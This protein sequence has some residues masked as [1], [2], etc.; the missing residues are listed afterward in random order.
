M[1]LHIISEMLTGAGVALGVFATG[2][3]LLF[4]YYIGKERGKSLK[5]N[6]REKLLFYIGAAGLLGIAA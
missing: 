2:L 3:F 1:F 4:V 5:H 6:Q